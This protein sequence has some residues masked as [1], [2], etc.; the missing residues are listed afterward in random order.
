MIFESHAH[1]E[2]SAF[3]EDREQLL[4]KIHSGLIETIVDVGSTLESS[5]QALELAKTHDYIY[6]AVGI[7]PEEIKDFG[8]PGHMIS[9]EV[10]GRPCRNFYP[11]QMP[12]DEINWQDNPVMLEIKEFAQNDRCVSIG[13]IGL[14]YYWV[15]DEKARAWQKYFFKA[16]LEMAAEMDLPVI[17]HSREAAAD[18]FS[19]MKE[20]TTNGVKA[21]IHSYSYS[22]EQARDYV[23]MGCYIG[24]G[25]VVTFKNAKKLIDVVRE[26]PL[27]RILVET[28]CPYMAPEPFRGMRNDSGLLPYIIKRIAQIKELTEYRVMETTRENGYDF[29]R[30]KRPHK[31]N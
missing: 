21:V 19:I 9:E 18:T 16:Q 8:I 27:E 7:H 10:D 6:A 25:G 5:R 13:E 26:A 31:G 2:D 29:Y 28:D 11:K 4:Q 12:P 24:V 15:K 22:P 14:D 23:D 17:V 30:I 20:A 1:F 3:D